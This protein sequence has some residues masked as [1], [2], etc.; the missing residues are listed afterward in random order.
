M[1]S[2]NVTDWASVVEHVAIRPSDKD[3]EGARLYYRSLCTLR[4]VRKGEPFDASNLGAKRPGTGLPTSIMAELFG[5]RAKRDLRADT[6]ITR[7][8]LE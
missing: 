5:R 8:D 2:A 7:D 6:L 4:D 3:L 1:P